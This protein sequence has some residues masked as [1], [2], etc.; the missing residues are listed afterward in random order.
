MKKIWNMESVLETLHPSTKK[1]NAQVIEPANSWAWNQPTTNCAWKPDSLAMTV[2][3][4]L[5]F[6]PQ[7]CLGIRFLCWNQNSS[8]SC[9]SQISIPLMRKHIFQPSLFGFKGT[10]LKMLCVWMC[11]LWQYGLKYLH[12]TFNSGKIEFSQNRTLR[13]GDGEAWAKTL[14]GILVSS[15]LIYLFIYGSL[16]YRE[17]TKCSSAISCL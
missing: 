1:N 13:G 5:F 4:A 11:V 8:S 6:L 2:C 9:S 12:S 17:C 14:S 10:F 16:C 15:L 7:R 3:S